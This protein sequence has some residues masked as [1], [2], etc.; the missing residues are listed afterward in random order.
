MKACRSPSPYISFAR[1][2]LP[3]FYCLLP[4]CPYVHVCP[5][6]FFHPCVSLSL[7]CTLL[8]IVLLMGLLYV[9]LS[10][11]IL[12]IALLPLHCFSVLYSSRRCI[13]HLWPRP[14]P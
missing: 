7:A 4:P 2:C 3:L 11:P 1:S 5:I 6:R 14:A 12:C 8:D 13:E 10:F 9:T